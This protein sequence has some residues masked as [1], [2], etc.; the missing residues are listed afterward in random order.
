MARAPAASTN[1]IPTIPT[2]SLNNAEKRA[3]SPG[4]RNDAARPVVVYRPNISPSRPFGARRARNE[5]E[6]AWAGPTHRHSASPNTQ[7]SVVPCTNSSTTH[8]TSSPTSE[9]MMIRLGPTRSSNRPSTSAPSAA[10]TFAATPKTRTV[11]WAMPYTL[12]AR[13]AP[14]LK[15]AARQSRD[16]AEAIRNLTALRSRRHGARTSRTSSR[17]EPRTSTRRCAGPAETSR[18]AKNTAEP[19]TANQTAENTATARMS[20]PPALVT[21]NQ[22]TGGAMK[23]T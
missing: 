11:D 13:I 14:K 5:R 6:L 8:E 18:T 1:A 10:T 21:P 7:N 15:T 12:T 17:Y 16:S 3:N 4:A 23:P 19:K 22:P 20:S 2:L 9:T